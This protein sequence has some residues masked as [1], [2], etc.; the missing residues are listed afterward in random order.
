M[1][2]ASMRLSSAG[3]RSRSS[4]WIN[5]SAAR[6]AA[7]SG[8]RC[9]RCASTM[10][11]AGPMAALKSR[12]PMNASRPRR[13][14]SRGDCVE[15]CAW[16]SGCCASSALGTTQAASA[17][18]AA[19]AP[20]IRIV[21]IRGACRQI[22]ELHL[23]GQ[24]LA[25]DDGAVLEHGPETRTTDV[26]QHGFVLE[27]DGIG[28]DQG[29]VLGVAGR[30]DKKPDR[31]MPT[32]R[33]GVGAQAARADRFVQHIVR[34][35]EPLPPQLVAVRRGAED[36][37]RALIL[38]ARVPGLAECDGPVADVAQRHR[39]RGGVA[40][41]LLLQEIQRFLERRDAHA[42]GV[43]LFAIRVADPEQRRY[44]PDVVLTVDLANHAQRPSV[45]IAL[46]LEEQPV[47]EPLRIFIDGFEHLVGAWRIG[48]LHEPQRLGLL[49][50][51]LAQLVEIEQRARHAI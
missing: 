7:Y 16:L 6:S 38:G 26:P 2:T 51:G 45:L 14:P 33:F 12:A 17:S 20:L 37:P 48:A 15:V 35:R 44:L 29:N 9:V 8:S 3:S 22:T 50:L 46:Q 10:L 27:A 25:D 39:R 5:P 30:V 47:A 43:A 4:A 23:N 31:D 40:L 36:L 34:A 42:R 11:F 19:M 1:S 13:R 28:L 49:R 21:A 41:R 18:T 24:A 32:Q